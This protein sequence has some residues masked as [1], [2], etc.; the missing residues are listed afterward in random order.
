MTF[1]FGFLFGKIYP[2]YKNRRHVTRLRSTSAIG[3][4]VDMSD[5]LILFGADGFS[6]GATEN[7]PRPGVVAI[8]TSNRAFSD[9]AFAGG[10]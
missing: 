2:V 6:H 8:P 4:A 3:G 10:A 9:S 1:A 7:L 5:T